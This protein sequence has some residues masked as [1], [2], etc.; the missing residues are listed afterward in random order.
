MRLLSQSLLASLVVLTA[1]CGGDKTSSSDSAGAAEGPP[2]LTPFQQENGVG[3]ITQVVPTGPIDKAMAERGEKTFQANCTACHKLDE[4]YVGPALR[5]VTDRRT[6]TYVMNMI[7]APDTMY[8][9]H[10]VARGLLAQFATQMP[11]LH[12]SETQARELMEYLREAS[13]EKH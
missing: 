1:A 3:P 8:T 9:R 2:A 11:N 4:R 7:L 12:L 5:G 13:A 6:P 10:P